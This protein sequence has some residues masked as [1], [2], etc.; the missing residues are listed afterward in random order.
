MGC[1]LI[2]RLALKRFH[3][4]YEWH[5]KEHHCK[6]NLN[7]HKRIVV[8]NVNGYNKKSQ[9]KIDQQLESSVSC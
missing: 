4:N 8:K 6:K 2:C 1:D 7:L 5:A 9:C 3:T